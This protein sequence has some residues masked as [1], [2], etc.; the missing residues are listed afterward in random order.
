MQKSKN[1]MQNEKYIKHARVL[2][3]LTKAV[4][5]HPSRQEA[6]AYLFITHGVNFT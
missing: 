3:I 5:F 4:A 6:T 1:N 2:C